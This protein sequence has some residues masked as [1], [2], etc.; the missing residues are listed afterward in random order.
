LLGQADLALKLLPLWLGGDWHAA[1]KDPV[2]LHH[3]LISV[4]DLSAML[5]PTGILRCRRCW[6]WHSFAIQKSFALF[7]IM[8]ISTMD[9]TPLFCVIGASEGYLFLLIWE[10]FST[11]PVSSVVLLISSFRGVDLPVIPFSW[12][13]LATRLQKLSPGFGSLYAY[14]GVREQINHRFGLLHG[15]LLHSFNIVDAITEGVNDLD[16]LDVQDAISGIAET[17]DIIVET[18]IMLLL[19]GLE[20]LGSRRTLIGA[21][22]V[23]HEHG[24][25]LVPGV[26]GSLE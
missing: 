10:L 4:G 23:L 15:Y 9:L 5:S 25:Q 17:L 24:T 11:V 13:P 18:L 3:M 14:I 2:D 1:S 6:W 8:S 7:Q 16:V 12:W 22:E 20:G 21:L 19:D 26:N